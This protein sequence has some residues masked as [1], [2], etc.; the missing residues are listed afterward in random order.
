GR[1]TA[2]EDDPAGQS[3]RESVASVSSLDRLS[4]EHR[5]R[6]A[7]SCKFLQYLL[8]GRLWQRCKPLQIAVFD[9]PCKQRPHVGPRI[10]ETDGMFKAELPSRVEV[11]DPTSDWRIARGRGS[12]Q[13]QVGQPLLTP[14]ARVE[15]SGTKGRAQCVPTIGGLEAS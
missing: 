2:G 14:K 8:T 4:H 11:Q 9:S 15:I 1:F 6:S 13:Q 10:G 12:L 5:G 7:V 3:D